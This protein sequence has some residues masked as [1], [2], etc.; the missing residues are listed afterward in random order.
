[1][2]PTDLKDNQSIV[3]E[4][5]VDHDDEYVIVPLDSDCPDCG[6]TTRMHFYDSDSER[7]WSGPKS[8]HEKTTWCDS[9]GLHDLVGYRKDME[10]SKTPKTSNIRKLQ[11]WATENQTTILFIIIAF[12]LASVL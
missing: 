9:L 6:Y 4:E 3:N 11:L 5:E 7:V 10:K 2:P 1:M 8:T 12:L